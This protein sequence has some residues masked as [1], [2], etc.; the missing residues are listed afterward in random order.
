MSES[1]AASANLRAA[2]TPSMDDL[3]QGDRAVLETNH[4]GLVTF[5][6]MAVSLCQFFDATIANVALPHMRA[7]LSAGPDQISWVLTSFIVATA[8]ATPLT[9]WLSDRIGS[10]NLFLLSTV[11]FLVASAACGAST[12]LSEMVVF[13]IVQGI[14]AAFIGPMTQTTVFDITPPSK[15][16]M[17]MAVFGMMVMVAP[18]TGPWVGGYLTQYLSWRWIYYVNLPIG[19]PALA[20]LWFYLPSRQIERRRFDLFGF[21]SIAVGLAAMQLA[22]DRGQEKDWFESWEIII[23][24]GV[25]FSAFWMFVIHTIST[26]NPLFRKEIFSNSA[27][28]MALGMM[29][30]MGVSVVGLSSVLPMLFQTIFHFPVI[31][32]GLMMAPRGIGVMITS[33]ACGQLVRRMDYRW[34][35]ASGYVIAAGGMW[36]M[37][38]WTIEMDKSV[39]Y[40]SIFVQGLGMGMLFS[41]MNLMAFATLP[42]QLR[43]DGS[44][45]MSLFRSL[46]GS[47]GISLIVTQLSRTQQIVHADSGAHITETSFPNMD[48]AAAIDRVGGMGPGALAM[49]DGEISR[50]AMMISYLN[51]FHMLTWMMLI[52]APIPFLLK[53]PVPQRE[54]GRQAVLE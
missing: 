10:R 46:G 13:R 48:W 38:T 11:M 3:E 5:A 44:G 31:D 14:S 53:R 40:L 1:N 32:S 21:F 17:A 43:P 34:L 23:E 49:I 39:M 24:A 45:L 22:L 29:L 30:L 37:T 35:I 54:A 28:L 27:F 18:I 25:A 15:Q 51:V 6:I 42:P 52:F 26:P 50:Q 36:M 4:R 8:I 12:T 33:F 9:G 41:P 20:I 7:A 16:A 2:A 47:V 19:I